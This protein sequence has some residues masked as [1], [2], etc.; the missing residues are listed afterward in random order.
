MTTRLT[1][2]YVNSAVR[3]SEGGLVNFIKPE[4]TPLCNNQ[5]NKMAVDVR[6]D[7]GLVDAQYYTNFGICVDFISTMYPKEKV[8]LPDGDRND[9]LWR[10]QLNTYRKSCKEFQRKGQ[11]LDE[12]ILYFQDNYADRPIKLGK[13]MSG[14]CNYVAYMKFRETNERG[15]QVRRNNVTYD[16]IIKEKF[17]IIDLRILREVSPERIVI[18]FNEKARYRYGAVGRN[19]TWHSAFLRFNDS[20]LDSAD[21][22][23]EFVREDLFN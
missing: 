18:N 11:S 16:D 4:L 23:N 19:D 8:L 1:S 6:T 20:D 12:S 9:V 17:R 15:V 2:D 7:K 14:H 5:R 10:K 13:I 3:I 22:T 21:V